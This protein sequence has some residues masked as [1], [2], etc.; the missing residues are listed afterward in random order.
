M[1]IKMELKGV[2]FIGTESSKEGTDIF[3]GF[4]PLTNQKLNPVYA[5]A[6]SEEIDK[7]VKKAK[8]AFKIYRTI[9]R[10]QKVR[11]LNS[12]ADE[13]MNLGDDLITCCMNETALSRDRLVGERTRTINQLNM[14]AKVVDEGSWVDARIDYATS[15]HEEVSKKD[16]RQMKIPLG[17]VVVFGAGNFPLAFSVSG[18]DTAS[19]LAAG[20]PVVYKAHPGHPATSEM[21]GYALLKAIRK[22]NMPEGVFSLIQ[23]ASNNVGAELVKHDDIKAVGFTGSFK[24]GKALFD[25]ANQ[26]NEPIPVYAEMGSTNPIFILPEAIENNYKTIADN[27][28][29]SFTLG[30]GQFCTNPGIVILTNSEKSELF[31]DYLKAGVEKAPAGT[32]LSERMK[33]NFDKGIKD[34]I[35]LSKLETI[36]TG[37]NASGACEATTHLLKTTADQFVDNKNL[38]LEVFGPSTLIVQAKDKAEIL[39]IANQLHG[40]LTITIHSFNNNELMSYSD[41][42]ETLMYKTGRLIIND[43]PTGVEVGNSM[44][45]GGP[46]PATTDSRFTSVG[47]AAIKRWVKPIC[48]QNFTNDLL[49][50]ELKNNNPINISRMIDGV[51]TY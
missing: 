10:E 19:A 49:P 29:T 20:C 25:L 36:S 13:I 48:F 44:H 7:A 15:N 9:S 30:V 11:F 50:D 5:N 43:F 24:A 46:F 8:N 28:I 37:T 41:L 47:T 26:R 51:N 42:I 1:K 23:G 33:S 31:L 35:H 16:I 6:T 3:Y 14:F 39:K 45:H 27:L 38:Q 40:H 21:L 32:M 22:T 17:P 12:I 18:G 2:H 4:N 34:L